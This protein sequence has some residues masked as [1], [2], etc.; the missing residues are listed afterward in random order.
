MVGL[1]S[2]ALSVMLKSNKLG[3]IN[4]YEVMT[5]HHGLVILKKVEPNDKELL[6]FNLEIDL[7]KKYVL[8]GYH[9][10]K[11]SSTSTTTTLIFEKHNNLKDWIM[12]N[13]LVIGQILTEDFKQ[14]LRYFLNQFL[15]FVFFVFNIFL[16]I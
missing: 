9:C 8:N 14:I 5:K 15:F 11:E 12:Q 10:F 7:D 4:V 6:S 3:L 1:T 2:I 13:R 16:F